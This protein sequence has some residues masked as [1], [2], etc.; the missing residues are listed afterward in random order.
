MADD[1]AGLVARLRAIFERTT[2]GPW[3]PYGDGVHPVKIG[4]IGSGDDF[5]ICRA[6]GPKGALNCEWIAAIHNDWPMISELLAEVENDEDAMTTRGPSE[7]EVIKWLRERADN[8][9]R[10]ATRKFG[11]DRDGWLEDERYFRAAIAA[12]IARGWRP[13]EEG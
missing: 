6:F 11:M 8:C 9:A 3:R 7:A 2:P 12:L 1:S 13:P 5:A 4:G 10:I